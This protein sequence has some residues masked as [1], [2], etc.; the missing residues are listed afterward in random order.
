M[1]IVLFITVNSF[2]CTTS[3]LLYLLCRVLNYEFLCLYNICCNLYKKLSIIKS[4]YIVN[5]ENNRFR[6]FNSTPAF[7]HTAS[8]RRIKSHSKNDKSDT[9]SQSLQKQSALYLS[10]QDEHRILEWMYHHTR[11]LASLKLK[12]LVKRERTLQVITTLMMH[13]K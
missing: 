6:L 13:V 5:Y 7:A 10:P 1:T 3:Y 8:Q 4:C 12:L 11:K 9:K 2:V